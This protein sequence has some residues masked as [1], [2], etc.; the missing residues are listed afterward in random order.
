PLIAMDAKSLDPERER[1]LIDV[2]GSELE[3]LEKDLKKRLIRDLKDRRLVPRHT[4]LGPKPE[5][6]PPPERVCD[7]AYLGIR[8]FLH[9]ATGHEDEIDYEVGAKI[10]LNKADG[11]K[12]K[13]IEEF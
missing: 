1:Q 5:E 8:H 7:A 2:A 11:V 9:V 10:F 13:I 4:N 3:V 12:D 6:V